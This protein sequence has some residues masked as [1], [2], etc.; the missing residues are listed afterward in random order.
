MLNIVCH[1]TF[2]EPPSICKFKIVFFSQNEGI[3]GSEVIAQLIPKLER[4]WT[5]VVSF[6]RR[7]FYPR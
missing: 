4:K 7:P 6:T 2:I 5:Q 3:W 1:V